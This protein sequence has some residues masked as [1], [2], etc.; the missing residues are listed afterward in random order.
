MAKQQQ[1]SCSPTTYTKPHN[2]T[3]HSLHYL[4]CQK[5]TK[6][7]L[8]C[9]QNAVNWWDLVAWSIHSPY[10]FMLE[11]AAFDAEP[12]Y[13]RN[14]NCPMGWRP[15]KTN[16]LPSA[17]RA[18]K[19]SQFPLLCLFFWLS[20]SALFWLLGVLFPQAFPPVLHTHLVSSKTI[21]DQLLVFYCTKVSLTST[22][23]ETKWM[24]LLPPASYSLF[25][26]AV[27]RCVPP[28]SQ[29]P[30]LQWHYPSFYVRVG[31][32]STST[33]PPPTWHI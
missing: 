5:G 16:A 3:A 6:R 13:A 2:F 20:S 23:K 32:I 15:R 12:R 4:Q 11:E 7:R 24:W 1:N 33:F 10:T 19:V 26:S 28:L 9:C 31:N 25:C 18:Q 14:T 29:N 17:M 27:R 30:Q 21:R 22:S 8:S